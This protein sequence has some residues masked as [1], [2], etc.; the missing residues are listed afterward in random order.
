MLLLGALSGIR[1]PEDYH[2]EKLVLRLES[3][4]L[5]LQN[6]LDLRKCEVKD[7][8]VKGE[9]RELARS[10]EEQRSEDEIYLEDDLERIRS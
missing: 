6:S 8:R 7:L 10:V 2:V 9:F 5:A 3:E 4:V 1:S